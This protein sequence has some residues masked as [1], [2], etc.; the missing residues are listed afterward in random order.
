MT[1]YKCWGKCS[2]ISILQ[3]S[4]SN[5]NTF[6]AIYSAHN[7]IEDVEALGNLLWQDNM[8]TADLFKH[9]FT[10]IEFLNQIK[11]NE[12]K[13]KTKDLWI[14]WFTTVSRATAKNVADQD[15]M[16][17]IKIHDRENGLRNFFVCLN[18]EWQEFLVLK[19]SWKK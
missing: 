10:P 13:T 1:V 17:H 4:S 5:K 9:N 11:F 6:T 18:S 14:H 8:E 2:H 3:T 19:W 12:E 16:S 7:V 15:W